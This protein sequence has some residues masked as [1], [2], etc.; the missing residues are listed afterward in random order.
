MQLK[1]AARIGTDTGAPGLRGTDGKQT[2]VMMTRPWNVQQV[3]GRLFAGAALLLCSLLAT[4][5]GYDAD[6]DNVGTTLF[7]AGPNKLVRAELRDG[8]PK[9]MSPAEIIYWSAKEN[10]VNPLL[11]VVK[12]QHEKDLLEPSFAD[13]EWQ[14]RLNGA[15]GFTAFDR[16]NGGMTMRGFFPQLVATSFQFDKWRNEFPTFDAGFKLYS[17]DTSATA[18]VKTLYAQYTPLFNRITGKS[19]SAAPAG[20][21]LGYYNDFRDAAIG[22]QHIQSLLDTFPTKL[23][24]RALFAATTTTPPPLVD[25]DLAVLAY[26]TITPTAD[27]THF[28]TCS[29]QCVEFVKANSGLRGSYGNAKNY[30]GNVLPGFGALQGNGSKTRPKAGDILVWSATPGN[31]VYGHVALVKS[32]SLSRSELIRVAVNENKPWCHVAETAM[33]I[34]GDASRGYTITSPGGWS[35]SGWRPRLTAVPLT[36]APYDPNVIPEADRQTRESFISELVSRFP[37]AQGATVLDKATQMGAL[38]NGQLSNP[39]APVSR[40]ETGVF[41]ARVVERQKPA[42]WA[43]AQPWPFPDEIVSAVDKAAIGKLR[44]LGVFAGDYSQESNG[45]IF[46]PNRMASQSEID[47]VLVRVQTLVGVMPSPPPPPP[48]PSADGMKMLSEE[49]LDDV[50]LNGLAQVNKRWTLSNT[51]SSTWTSAYCLRPVPGGPALGNAPRCISGTVPPGGSQVLT[52]PM[53]MPAA[54]PAAQKLRQTWRLSNA[55]GT[56]VGPDIWAQFVVN[57]SGGGTGG[58]GGGA[59]PPVNPQGASYKAPVNPFDDRAHGRPYAGQC[60]WFAWGRAHEVTGKRLDIVRGDANTWYRNTQYPKGQQPRGNAVAVWAGDASNGHGHVAFVEQVNGNNVVITEANI[61]TYN[62]NK[63]AYPP[64]GGGY[65]GAPKTLSVAAM[66]QRG[67]GVGALL[68]YIYVADAP[69]PP[70]RDPNLVYP[71]ERT[72]TRGEF[73]QALLNDYPQLDRSNLE[74]TA[75]S[76]GLIQGALN[77]GLPIVRG[78]AAK[79]V[80]RLIA[81]TTKVVPANPD[82]GHYANDAELKADPEALAAANTLLAAGIARGE[83][84]EVK[85]QGYEFNPRRQLSAAES[86][87]MDQRTSQFLSGSVLKQAPP[88]PPSAD[89][90]KMLSEEPVDDVALN[91]LAQVNKRWTLSNTGSST[92]TSAYCLRPAPGGPA[93]GNAPRC[94]SGTVPPGGSQALTVPMV[95]PAAQAAAQKL[96][97]T[98]QLFNAQGKQVG[99]DIWAQ[100]V[101][102]GSAPGVQIA[103]ARALGELRVNKPAQF[104]LTGTALSAANPPRLSFSDCDQARLDIASAVRA[105]FNCT[106]RVASAAARLFWK[107]PGTDAT[108]HELGRFNV[109]AEAPVA[110]KIQDPLNLPTLVRLP[111]EAW[112]GVINL[113]AAASQV[114]LNLTDA[115]G[116]SAAVAMVAEGPLRWTFRYLPASPG[117][118]QWN[119]TAQG[120][121]GSDTRSGSLQVQGDVQPPPTVAVTANPPATAGQ[122]WTLQAQTTTPATQVTLQIGIGNRVLMA[123]GDQRR[124]SLTQTLNQPGRFDATVRAL[125][126]NGVFHETA[127]TLQVAAAGGGNPPPPPPPPPGPAPV[128]AVSNISVN[129][130][131]KPVI[132]FNVQPAAARAS[133]TIEGRTFQF[134]CSSGTQVTCDCVSVWPPALRGSFTARIEAFDAGGRSSGVKT[135]S[136]TR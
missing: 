12:M 101:V 69:Q 16:L 107:A 20:N 122:P 94:I 90:M 45:L 111:S 28:D 4:A 105:V 56:Q 100:F 15:T 1:S 66:A 89:G 30:A 21:G 125:F 92:W 34:T 22:P 88:P 121:S 44:R 127:V 91:G 79:M 134:N 132:Q 108:E 136:F 114:R 43:A 128:P 40:L 70:E 57:G 11:L 103:A 32:V 97:Q 49:P 42:Q 3:L 81:A 9:S 5:A 23:K 93:L 102:N 135:F 2:R 13:S 65:D 120:A 77:A 126:G 118:Y 75:R 72:V 96:R 58:G 104:E 53:V 61:S 29:P 31:A 130:S 106:P 74:L 18:T 25:P 39:G 86:T 71:P 131:G 117:A 60:T 124:F 10:N 99:P 46:H 112:S 47:T 110:L 80:A 8:R 24:D 36:A 26:T 67:T 63:G 37:A 62:A 35:F 68:G 119:L 59:A 17:S 133:L 123:S 52:V 14:T 84:H 55:Q 50:A 113:S 38:V 78:D 115:Q 41:L 51:G 83:A 76:L 129:P 82:P 33:R 85:G 6:P 73:V 64:Y 54:Q 19:Y 7:S 109:L 95:M 116:R 87:V 98:W 48:P 27:T